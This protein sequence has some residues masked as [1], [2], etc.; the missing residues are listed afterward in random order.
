MKKR[1]RE[2]ELPNTSPRVLKPQNTIRKNRITI[3]NFN[4]QYFKLN[5]K[6]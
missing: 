3:I 6:I 2:D 4:K 1:N 5:S